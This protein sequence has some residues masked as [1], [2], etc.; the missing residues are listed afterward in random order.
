M[1]NVITFEC[2]HFCIRNQGMANVLSSAIPLDQLLVFFTYLI[3]FDG[4][5]VA[6]CSNRLSVAKSWTVELSVAKY[7]VRRCTMMA[8]LAMAEVSRYNL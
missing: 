7:H 6:K 4:L 8:S 3:E 5:S 1:D 2:H